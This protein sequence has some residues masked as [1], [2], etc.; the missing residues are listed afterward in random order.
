MRTEEYLSETIDMLT[1][2]EQ[3]L[4]R[5][6]KDLP[7]EN[8]CVY[9]REGIGYL[10]KY[11]PGFGLRS[12]RKEQDPDF[13]IGCLQSKTYQKS[14]RAIRSNIEILEKCLKKYIPQEKFLPDLEKLNGDIAKLYGSRRSSHMHLTLE[15]A[16][17]RAA[18]AGRVVYSQDPF[19]TGPIHNT[20]GTRHTTSFGLPVASK[21]EITIAEKLYDLGISFD[22][23]HE[24]YLE[25]EYG[26][27]ILIHP[28]FYINGPYGRHVI[29]EHAGMINDEQYRREFFRRI[30][31]YISAGLIMPRDF[32]YTITESDGDLDVREIMGV[33]DT[34]RRMGIC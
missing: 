28:D 10:R 19:I 32:M 3:S 17:E 24:L 18:P 21:N 7:N 15:A 33:I 5:R 4:A 22:Y 29:W 30:K 27:T 1:N 16:P 25:D 14:I 12:Y 9:T 34:L 6:V 13:V 8:L 26:K 31:L 20:H 2:M 23:E 11:V